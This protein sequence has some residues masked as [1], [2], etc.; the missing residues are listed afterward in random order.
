ALILMALLFQ[1]GL[2][3]RATETGALLAVGWRAQQ[4]RR[5][6][7][8]EGVLL[9]VVGAVLGVIGGL[10]YAKAILYALTTIWRGAVG[11]SA[12]EFH[13]SVTSIF[14]GLL[15]SVF[16]ALIV[17]WFVL[18]KQSKRPARE[19]LERG[20]ENESLLVTN[21]RAWSK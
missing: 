2:E 7:L 3:Q 12:L 1:F 4:V 18:R 20:S 17:I 15:S 21:K 13:A 16:L 19:L 8:I 10:V 5:F 6:L 14:I 9:A 11:T